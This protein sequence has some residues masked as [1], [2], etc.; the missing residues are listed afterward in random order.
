M[1]GNFNTMR[2]EHHTDTKNPTPAK[3]ISQVIGNFN[4]VNRNFC[5]VYGHYNQ[6]NGNFAKSFGKGNRV[7]VCVLKT[8][9]NRIIDNTRIQFREISPL[10]IHQGNNTS[11]HPMTKSKW[12]H[13]MRRK[14]FRKVRLEREQNKKPTNA[15]L[16]ATA[17]E[18]KKSDDSSDF[19]PWRQKQHKSTRNSQA[20]LCIYL[21]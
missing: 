7:N 9:R 16:I 20:S 8:N 18:S 19:K 6:V 10:Q 1:N 15:Q 11:L 13:G 21:L 2:G 5:H 4:K 3:W 12:H 17:R 14:I